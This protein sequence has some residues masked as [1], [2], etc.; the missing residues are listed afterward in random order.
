MAA[1]S[2]TGERLY[3]FVIDKSKNYGALKM[4]INF[5]ADT[6]HRKIVA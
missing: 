5:P 1:A 6:E 2:A 3:M 4:Q